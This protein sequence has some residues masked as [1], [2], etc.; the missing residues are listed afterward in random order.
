MFV[1]YRRII[2]MDGRLATSVEAQAVEVFGSGDEWMSRFL[3]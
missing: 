1:A 2:R 3:V